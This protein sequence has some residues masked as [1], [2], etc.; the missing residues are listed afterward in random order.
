MRIGIH[1]GEAIHRQGDFFGRSVVLAARIA[2]HAQ[3]G[4][5]L[6]SSLARDLV[7]ERGDIQLRD[8]GETEF[9]GLEGHHRL[10]EVSWTE[11]TAP[12][13]TEDAPTP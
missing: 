1:T 2:S 4:D 11:A 7:A 13:L 12:S 3:G 5:I 8:A 6:V 9:K 10:F